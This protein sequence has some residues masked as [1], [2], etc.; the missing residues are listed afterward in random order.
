LTARV[1]IFGSCVTRDLFEYPRLRP[2]LALYAARSSVISTTA[3]AVA[4]GAHEVTLKSKFQKRCVLVDFQKS[5]WR[6]LKEVRPDWLVVDLVDERFDLLRTN[7]SFVTRS[8]AFEA[9]GLGSLDRYD[10]QPVER[11]SEDGLALFDDA[12]KRF[13][14]RATQTVPP[15]RIVLHRARWLTRYREGDRIEDFPADRRRFADW[16]NQTLERGYEALA[17]Q[18]G[19]SCAEVDLDPRRYAADA[20]HRWELEPFH[21]E[22]AYNEAAIARLSALFGAG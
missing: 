4:I 12:S 3:P 22:P 19:R 6:Q 18:L 8:S 16:M 15:E 5:F 2:T 21:Y 20:A 13:V 9:A 1:A 11:H 7:G 17:E 14:H 10:W